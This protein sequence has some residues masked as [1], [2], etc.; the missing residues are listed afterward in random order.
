MP[1]AYNLTRREIFYRHE[2]FTAGLQAAG[3][4]VRTAL[5]QGRHGDVLLIWN[6][7]HF[8]QAATQFEAAGGKVIVAENGYLGPGGISPHSMD[9]RTV[10]A[11]GLG[12]HNDS[13]AI[14]E[15][16]LD[17]WRAL[18]VDLKPWRTTGEHV[19][20]CPNRSFGTP[21]RVMPPT[22]AADVSARLKKLTNREIRIRPHPGNRPAEKPLADDLSGAWV[23]VIWSSSAGVHALVAGIPVICESPAW[24]GMKAAFTAFASEWDAMEESEPD[25]LDYNRLRAMSDVARGQWSV[26]EI[27]S[28]EPFRLLCGTSTAPAII[29]A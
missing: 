4:E 24:I 27:A 26:E 16:G 10:F 6:R 7:Y 5:P 2:A 21:G 22:W 9:P 11:L 13:A 23:C 17:R 12:A 20:V 29:T 28:G 8:H 14:P 18:G 3:Y 19:L 15:G 25:Y 1:I